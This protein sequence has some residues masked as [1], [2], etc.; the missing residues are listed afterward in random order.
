MMLDLEPFRLDKLFVYARLG[1]FMLDLNSVINLLCRVAN[2]L[3]KKWLQCL[4]H[5]FSGEEPLQNSYSSKCRCY[6][7]KDPNFTRGEKTYWLLEQ[8]EACHEIAKQSKLDQDELLGMVGAA[9]QIRARRP[10]LTTPQALLL[11]EFCKS[12][13]SV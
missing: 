10:C 1:T 12:L 7:A 6:H 9:C 3:A 8:T 2:P 4:L 13:S 11:K 5:N